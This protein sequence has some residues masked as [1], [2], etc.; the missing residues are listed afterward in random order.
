MVK[1][2]QVGVMLVELCQT[3]SDAGHRAWG[4]GGYTR[5]ALRGEGAYSDGRRPDAVYTFPPVNKYLP[6]TV[7]PVLHS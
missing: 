6:T 2:E 3:L 7:P 5:D 4:G 1:L